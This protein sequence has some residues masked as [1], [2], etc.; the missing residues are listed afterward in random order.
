MIKDYI[1]LTDILYIFINK[2]QLYKIFVSCCKKFVLSWESF[3]IYYS[4]INIRL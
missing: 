4:T 1:F 3:V 2:L